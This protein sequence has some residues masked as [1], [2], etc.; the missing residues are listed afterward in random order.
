M[1]MFKIRYL[2]LIV[3]GVCIFSS[4]I[5]SKDIRYMQGGILS[6]N[7]YQ[8]K[9]VEYLVQPDD[10]LYVKLSSTEPVT[11]QALSAESANNLSQG[12]AAK[13]KDVYQVDKEG[14]IKLP[15]FDKIKVDG[16]TLQQIRDTVDTI[17]SKFYNQ[18]SV[19]VRLAD[20]YATILGDVNNPG[21]Y[22]IDFRD[23]INI[24]E[25]IGMAGDLAFEAKR[26]DVKL[27]RKRGEET[28]IISLDLTKKNILESEYYYIMPNDIVYVEPL[29]AVTWNQRS[30]PFATTIALV[31][32]TTTTILV[33][34]S[35]FK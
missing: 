31:L 15:Q 23:K 30:F 24:F 20:N 16:K 2:Y 3:S 6:N 26:N 13:Y 21:R 1:I 25:L 14:Y 11:D 35:Y 33:I 5:T 28:E 7:K 18:V 4:C 9:V 27:L 22:M 8:N 29:K 10:N 17:G 12:L 34:I 19:Q 32:S